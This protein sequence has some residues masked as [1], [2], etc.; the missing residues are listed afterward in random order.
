[1]TDYYWSSLNDGDVFGVDWP[2]FDPGAD[3]LV[4]DGFSTLDSSLFGSN[5]GTDSIFAY[6]GKTVTLDV[7]PREITTGNVWFANGTQL[8]IGDNT[9]GVVDDDNANSIIGG[10]GE[11]LLV[12][13]G[14]ADN[15][16]GGNGNDILAVVGDMAN[17]VYGADTLDGGPG[18]DR[19]IFYD[20]ANGVQLSLG[21]SSD[22][23]DGA[24]I[25]GDGPLPGGPYSP[26]TLISIER[27]AGT[28]FDDSLAANS[29][30]PV[31]GL[32]T[33]TVQLLDGAGGDD[34]LTGAA[35][36][37]RITIIEYGT[38]TSGVIVNIGTNPVVVGADTVLGQS[39]RD[40]RGGT[41]SLSDIDGVWGSGYDD[42]LAG[43]SPSRA[44]GGEFLEIFRGNAGNDTLDGGASDSVLGGVVSDRADYSNSPDPVVVNLGSGTGTANDGFGGTDTLI[45]IEQVFGSSGNDTLSGNT[46]GG[47][48]NGGAGDDRIDGLGGRDT[49]AYRTA[50]SG[51]I[52]NLGAAP[53]VVG[54]ETVAGGTAHDG[55]G[56]V[57]TLVGIEQI[58]GSDFNDYLVG[59]DMPVQHWFI[60][61]KGDDTM[62]GA[63]GDVDTA[64][65]SDVP[66]SSGGITAYLENGAGWASDGY[67]TVDTLNN[68]EVL[69]G[70]Y[71]GDTLTGGAGDQRFRALGGDDQVDGGGG[72][73]WIVYISDPGSVYIDLG[74]GTATDGWGPWELGGTDTLVSIE[75]AQGSGLNDTIVGSA[76]ANDLQGMSG[77]DSIL[78][79]YGADTLRGGAGIDTL[80]GGAGDDSLDGGFGN[81]TLTGGSGLDSLI[82]GGGDDLHVVSSTATAGASRIVFVTDS[83]TENTGGGLDTVSSSSSYTLPAN[84]ENLI[85]TGAPMWRA[86]TGAG[87]DGGNVIESQG[88]ARHLLFG[89]G[90][91]DTLVGG[92]GRDVL[93][94]GTGSDALTGGG[95]DDILVWDALDASVQGGG[96]EDT[97]QIAGAGVALDLR[98][99]PDTLIQDV[100]VV[101]LAGSGGNAI[102]L[103]YADVLAISSTD[104]LRVDGNGGDDT[105]GIA[106]IGGWTQG[107]DQAIGSE[108]YRTY[109][110][111]S[112]TLL[113][114]TDLTPFTPL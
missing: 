31:N 95:G 71:A 17:A 63:G 44:A 28:W 86:Y 105:F 91:D 80:S 70:S 36:N 27:A 69:Q 77:N 14:G 15:I 54:L 10:T 38:A 9:T 11:D 24:S 50:T 6:A 100:E 59:N 12:G 114:D 1:M 93:D 104:T 83:V 62:D 53:L 18:D 60:G 66:L 61:G 94:G 73:D 2:S 108:M 51:V 46:G 32:D 102:A 68:I 76:A 75:N 55:E 8:I 25:G 87:N 7:S 56:G 106:D 58:W 4:F 82:G 41:D 34:T 110:Q 74:A 99:I 20:A 81:D 3:R 19:V 47:V 79:G 26:I 65:Y 23:S 57:D 109:T 42:Y 45:G 112:A 72:D 78:G 103:T 113:V 21:N 107:A 101:D 35:G 88:A 97:L 16:L 84:V 89:N 22:F 5:D 67:G 48:Y 40:G 49:A 37:G 33:D 64:A 111:A 30:S 92:D 13:G 52:A 90:G 29:A 85:L 98:I 96:G 43:G 39:A